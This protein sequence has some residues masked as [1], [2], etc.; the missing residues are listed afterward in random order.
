MISVNIGP[1]SY[2]GVDLTWKNAFI[3]ACRGT[4][5]DICVHRLLTVKGASG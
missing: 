1:N 4:E 5:E 2:L 3:I